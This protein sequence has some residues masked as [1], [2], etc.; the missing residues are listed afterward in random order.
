RT[1]ISV[2]PLKSM[3]KFRPW[4]KNSVIATIESSAEIGKLMRRKRVKS[5]CVSSGT[6]RSDGSQP[7]ALT[8]VST[9]MRMPSPIRTKCVTAGSGF[10]NGHALR[11][12]PPYPGC[13]DQA[14]K[15]ERGEN[16]GDDADAE[17]HREAAYRAG[18]DIE[19]HGGGD[20]SGDVG[21]KDRRQRALE[22]SVDGRDRI[23]P[24]A[25]F[26]ADALIDQNVGIDRDTDGQHDAG[27]ARQ[28]ER[29]V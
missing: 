28:S 15:R 26:F 14:G 5:K 2:P 8:T 12:R 27:N 18:A 11:P 17:R 22:A 1:S 24:A 9:A 25:Q 21:I 7:N 4:V 6:I 19:Q 23:A 3:P 29:G 16:R 20:E 13:H 10:S